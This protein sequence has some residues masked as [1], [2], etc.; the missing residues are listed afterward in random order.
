MV[1]TEFLW[2]N[3][4]SSINSLIFVSGPH[5]QFSPL[6][7]LYSL[8]GSPWTFPIF[9]NYLPHHFNLLSIPLCSRR[10]L[11]ILFY[12]T[13]WFL[14]F[15]LSPFYCLLLSLL[16]LAVTFFKFKRSF[17]AWDFHNCLLKCINSSL[18]W[19][20]MWRQTRYLLKKAV[21]WIW[22]PPQFF[23][24]KTY[25]YRQYDI[26]LFTHHSEGTICF[27]AFAYK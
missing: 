7:I 17:I 22:L 23:F 24:L 20:L 2:V 10:V 3:Q 9:F 26:S 8:V 12:F 27:P 25:I 21:L 11:Q 18:S 6:G 5:T 19:I 13:N 14:F 16:N 1:A 4:F 15:L